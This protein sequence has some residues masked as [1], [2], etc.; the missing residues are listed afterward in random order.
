MRSNKY[1]IK[2]INLYLHHQLH[3]SDQKVHLL[4]QSVFIISNKSI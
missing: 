1:D 2:L 4:T 3:N